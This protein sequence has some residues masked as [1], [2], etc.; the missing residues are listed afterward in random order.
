MDDEN[1]GRLIS[2]IF[3]SIGIFLCIVAVCV[4]PHL[5]K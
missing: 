2:L 5:I 1:G 4:I 3:F